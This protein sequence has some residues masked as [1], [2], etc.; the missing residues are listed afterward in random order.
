MKSNFLKK[1]VVAV[2]GLM[3]VGVGIGFI[4]LA[5]LGV[6]PASVFQTGLS[7][8]LNISYG[9]A[10]ALV[11]VFILS[12]IFF[13]DK[14]YISVSSVLAIF[15]IGYVADFTLTITSSV[16]GDPNLII[17]RALLLL[18]GTFIMGFGVAVYIRAKLGVGAIDLVSEIISDRSRFQYRYIRIAADFSFIVVGFLLGGKLGVGTIV[19]ALVT[20]PIVQFCRPGVDGFISRYLVD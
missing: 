18:V 17:V 10:S 12:I 20:G 11:N 9:N 15:C 5:D 2:I 16:I 8:Q 7:K 14:K 13:I 3:I 4:L 6:D 1:I 19:I